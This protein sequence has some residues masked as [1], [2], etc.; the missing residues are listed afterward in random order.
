MKARTKF[1]LIELKY[2]FLRYFN[3]FPFLIIILSISLFM[4]LLA[5]KLFPD[6]TDDWTIAFLSALIGAIIGTASSFYIMFATRKNDNIDKIIMEKRDLIY[7]PF[8]ADIIKIKQL[9]NND[10][11]LD[12]NRIG[13]PLWYEIRE[14]DTILLLSKDM[15]RLLESYYKK[16]VNYRQKYID[17]FTTLQEELNN[18]I[19]KDIQDLDKS[20]VTTFVKY[21]FNFKIKII[22]LGSL[23]LLRS[24][25]GDTIEST[26]NL[27]KTETIQQFLLQNTQYQELCSS[28]NEMIRIIQEYYELFQYILKSIIYRF[29]RDNYPI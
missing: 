22:E 7:K 2:A 1:Q 23:K 26:V 20:S 16:L 29:Y 6:L 27:E 19:T 18:I 21:I 28:S 9:I 10:E 14:T 24:K 17:T 15:H 3:L 25:F 11:I 13:K 4:L 12:H 8:Y 5:T